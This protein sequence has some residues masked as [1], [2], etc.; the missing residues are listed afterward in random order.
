MVAFT[1]LGKH[2]EPA[3]PGSG[4]FGLFT[5][6]MKILRDIIDGLRHYFSTKIS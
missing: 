3:L 6:E 2:S 1:E 4:Q 5:F